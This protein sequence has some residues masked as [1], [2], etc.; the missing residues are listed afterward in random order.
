MSDMF[1]LKVK[2][3]FQHSIEVI[4]KKLVDNVDTAKPLCLGVCVSLAPDTLEGIKTLGFSGHE[5]YELST[6]TFQLRILLKDGKGILWGASFRNWK[7]PDNLFGGHWR[8]FKIALVDIEKTK[9]LP[10]KYSKTQNITLTISYLQL[11]ISSS[12]CDYIQKFKCPDPILESI[13]LPT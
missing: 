4:K 10:T 1:R 9:T 13:K 11:F 3:K 6:M 5:D 8:I 2:D 12:W 7:E